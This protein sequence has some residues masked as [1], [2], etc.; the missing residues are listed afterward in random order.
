MQAVDE[1]GEQREEYWKN[2]IRPF[3]QHI[4]PKSNDLV[5]KSIATSVARLCISDHEEFPT[6]LST[7]IDWL[8]PIEHP[9]FIVHKLYESGITER[10]PTESIRFLSTIIDRTSSASRELMQCLDVIAKASP[11]LKQN[12]EFQRLLGIANGSN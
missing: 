8:R 1:A 4:W 7:L 11:V 10:F 5:T 2:R 6:T 12:S 3:W 9:D